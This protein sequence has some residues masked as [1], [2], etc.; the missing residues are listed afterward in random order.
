YRRQLATCSNARE[1]RE[2]KNRYKAGLGEETGINPNS[3]VSDYSDTTFRYFSL[4][5]LFSRIGQTIVIRSNKLRFVQEL[6]QSEPTFLF[7]ANPTQYLEAYYKNNFPLPTDPSDSALQAINSLKDGI[8]DRNNP[9][10][11]EANGLSP[12]SEIAD[13]QRIRLQLIEYN[14]WEREEHFANEQQTPEAI[15]DIINYLKVLNGETVPDGPEIDD[16]PA[17]LEW[18]VWR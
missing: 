13:I 1:I 17:Y 12:T 10:L 5:G 3:V 4:S 18:A 6:L 9:L 11:T 2:L 15:S 7:S 8:R 16:R 14:N